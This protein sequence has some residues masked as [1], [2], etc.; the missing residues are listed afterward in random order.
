MTAAGMV[1]APQAVAATVTRIGRC[2]FCDRTGMVIEDID[3]EGSYYQCLAC[4]DRIASMEATGFF[5][6]ETSDI[7]PWEAADG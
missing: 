2:E 7:E 3:D 5:A 4:R 6:C 1:D